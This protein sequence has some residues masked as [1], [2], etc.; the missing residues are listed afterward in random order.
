MAELPIYDSPDDPLDDS[1]IDFTGFGRQ[2]ARAIDRW[3]WSPEVVE[4]RTIPKEGEKKKIVK[5]VQ[6]PGTAVGGESK[7]TK[8]KSERASEGRARPGQAGQ[9]RAG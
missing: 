2:S 6:S 7:K 4:Y 3:A 5:G 1:M 9:S 8:S